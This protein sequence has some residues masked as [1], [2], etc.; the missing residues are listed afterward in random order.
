[1]KNVA[2]V[3]QKSQQ[4]PWFQQKKHV[5]LKKNLKENRAK[6]LGNPLKLPPSNL[7]EPV[8]L[9]RKQDALIA[10]KNRQSA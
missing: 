5:A 9:K 7:K 6:T 4:Q 1:M 10:E 3:H 2:I 8:A